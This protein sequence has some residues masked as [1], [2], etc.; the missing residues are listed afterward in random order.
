M[1][2]EFAPLFLSA[3]QW[4]V[5]GSN[6]PKLHL[7]GNRNVVKFFVSLIGSYLSGKWNSEDVLMVK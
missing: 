7:F 5:N 2:L 1:K 4:F 6:E 3:I